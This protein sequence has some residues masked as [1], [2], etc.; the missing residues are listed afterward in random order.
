MI[1]EPTVFIL[2]AGASNPYG[3][4]DGQSLLKVIKEKLY[5]K[6]IFDDYVSWIGSGVAY[7]PDE[8]RNEIN[9]F[10]RGLEGSDPKSIDEFLAFEKNSS[11]VKLGKYLIA[12]IINEHDPSDKADG[13]TGADGNWYQS[14]KTRMLQGAESKIEKFLNNQVSFIT[15]NYDSTLEE[16]FSRVIASNWG[17]NYID[18]YFNAIPHIHIHGCL[19]K[20]NVVG[21]WDLPFGKKAVDPAQVGKISK[22][23]KLVH[24]GEDYPEMNN[25]LGLISNA[26][27]LVFLGFGFHE[28]NLLKL[29]LGQHEK[30]FN[31]KSYFATVKGMSSS[32]QEAA[33]ARFGRKVLETSKFHLINADCV[34]LFAEFDHELGS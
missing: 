34:R 15:F 5:S 23:I 8:M 1:H 19:K 32:E 30:I 21:G 11:F 12:S 14:L 25:V 31:N 22:E 26:K 27:K 20:R 9:G 33:K 4:P 3:F 13:I 16:Y 18:H 7:H 2:G 28:N 10:K 29:G 24:E 17:E 6:S